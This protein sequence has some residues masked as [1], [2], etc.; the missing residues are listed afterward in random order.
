MRTPAAF[1]SHSSINSDTAKRLAADLRASGVDVWYA[2]WEL[3]PGDS[4][5]QKI[6]EGIDR[7]THF[8]VLLTSESLKSEWVKTELDAAMVN[9]ISGKCR[10]IP[11]L[12]GVNHDQV[13][14]T[15]RGLVYVPLESY[16]SGLRRLIE[17]CHDVS[18]KP[19]L[20]QPPHWAERPLP[21][22]GLSPHAQRL[23]VFLNRRS[24]IGT[25]HEYVA[26]AELL[27]ELQITPLE[28]GG[29]ASELEDLGMVK[30]LKTFGCGEAGFSELAPSKAF[31]IATD[32][33]L[34]N[35]NP[36]EDAVTLAAA[37]V[38]GGE[39][40]GGLADL[41]RTL[42]WGA[43]RLNPAA[44]YLALN[45]IIRPFHEMGS[46]PYTFSSA[47][48]THRTRRFAESGRL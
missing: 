37:M 4:L 46:H 6:D 32:S 20:G 2:E 42:G 5:R 35:W 31:F 8:L 17:V 43:R 26:Q 30:L 38:N 10:L 22:Y 23:V 25:D 24:E 36:E 44:N 29:A 11:I 33:A 45:G 3:K 27:Q 21:N 28:L 40:S 16:N 13:P 9:R 34:Q 7:A 14:A 12:L 1:F 48:I 15:L 41:D 39:Q 18:V 47:A 19:P